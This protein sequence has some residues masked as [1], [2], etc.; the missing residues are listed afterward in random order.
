LTEPVCDDP[1]DDKFLACAVTAHAE[2]IVSGDRVLLEASGYEGIQV[3]TTKD[4]VSELVIEVFIE[5]LICINTCSTEVYQ[6]FRGK[7]ICPL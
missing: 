3:M 2:I 4:F 7:V 6:S 1:D 5:V